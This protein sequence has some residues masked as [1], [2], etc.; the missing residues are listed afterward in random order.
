MKI[1][2]AERQ[3]LLDIAIQ[4]S[5]SLEAAFALSVKNDLGL[6]EILATDRALE[7]VAVTDQLVF[8]RYKV[9]RLQPAT[10]ISPEDQKAIPYGGIGF[11]GIEVD[12]IVS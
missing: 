11:M 7:T 6:S 9:K 4:T 2:P 8:S 1:T 5:G 12:F 3:S 10:A